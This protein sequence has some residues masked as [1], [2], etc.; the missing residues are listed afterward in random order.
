[1]A[2]KDRARLTQRLCRFL[3]G[4]ALAAGGLLDSSM[5]LTAAEPSPPA[6][7]F[8]TYI[9]AG[10]ATR[11]DAAEAPAID[12]LL[13]DGAWAKAKVIDE[14]YQLDPDT[15]AP[16]TERTELRILYDNENLYV[17]IYNY[18]REPHLISNTQRSR[19]GAETSTVDEPRVAALRAVWDERDNQ[20]KRR[21]IQW[22]LCWRCR[23]SICRA[24]RA[25]LDPW[26][27]R[28]S[29]PSRS[30]R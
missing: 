23:S 10:E 16:G 20:H 17:G 6:R 30:P 3:T 19:D 27:L 24:R 18:D 28:F 21:R 13:D 26:P 12:G 22:R 15:G 11:I 2:L 7:D 4:T 1:M 8:S 14:F 25:R 9:P 29:A 5:P